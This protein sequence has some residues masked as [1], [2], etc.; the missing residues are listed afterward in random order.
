MKK[1]ASIAILAG[2]VACGGESETGL[3]PTIEKTYETTLTKEV[4]H[5]ENGDPFI[6]ISVEQTPILDTL[7]P[8]ITTANMAL[9]TYS[10]LDEEERTNIPEIDIEFKKSGQLTQS[11]TYEVPFMKGVYEKAKVFD[12]L[13]FALLNRQFELLDQRRNTEAVKQGIAPLLEQKIEVLEEKYGPLQG[14]ETFGLAEVGGQSGRAY[15]F[16]AFL[17]F[18]EQKIP[19]FFYLDTREE[20]DQWLG[21]SIQN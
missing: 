11:F 19:Y 2:I 6:K 16:Q 18:G 7:H 15:Q 14:Y 10:E 13:S 3:K 12:Q 4:L 1:I 9:M 5:R 17:N 20:E 21:F 8:N